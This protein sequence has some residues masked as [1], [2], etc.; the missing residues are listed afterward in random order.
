MTA[1]G[2]IYTFELRREG[3]DYVGEVVD[4]YG[5]VISIRGTLDRDRK[6]IVGTGTLGSTPGR[7]NAP[8]RA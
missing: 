6:A 5:W 3:G 4:D 7:G 8:E 1:S 2:E